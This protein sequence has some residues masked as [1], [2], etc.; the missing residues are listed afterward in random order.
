[1]VQITI[2]PDKGVL[3]SLTWN[4]LVQEHNRKHGHHGS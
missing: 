1:M 3:T 4:T 2:T